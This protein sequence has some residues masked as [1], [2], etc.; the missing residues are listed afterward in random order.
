MP[1]SEGF[2][3][4]PARTQD[5]MKAAAGLFKAYAESL[6]PVDL[7]F[8]SFDA[9]LASLP[10]QYEPPGGELLLARDANDDAIGCVAIRPQSE[11]HCCEIKRLYVGPAGRGLGIGRAL[12]NKIMQVARE[13]QYRQVRLD[14]LSTMAAAIS[15]YRKA[16][17]HEIGAYYETPVPDTIFFAKDLG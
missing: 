7:T 1:A 12:M 10:G 16:G 2:S 13:M 8:Q 4:H 3:I 15:M 14:T 5:D 17:F 11:S 6:S 9:E